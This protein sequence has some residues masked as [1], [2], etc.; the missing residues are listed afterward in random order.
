MNHS[1]SLL[2][3]QSSQSSTTWPYVTG[4]AHVS[5][6]RDGSGW[7]SAGVISS[8]N[9][10]FLFLTDGEKSGTGRDPLDR[11]DLRKHSKFWNSWDHQNDSFQTTG[12]VKPRKI[13]SRM[14]MSTANINYSA[15]KRHRSFMSSGS[16]VPPLNNSPWRDN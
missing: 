12:R 8:Q 1:L 3:R 13:V 11:S 9:Q 6:A 16:L 15:W 7:P 10:G 2:F 14:L 5:L 4:P